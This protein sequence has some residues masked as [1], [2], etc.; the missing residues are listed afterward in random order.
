MVNDMTEFMDSA[1]GRKREWCLKDKQESNC[2]KLYFLDEAWSELIA[3]DK[4]VTFST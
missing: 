2:G 1:Y 3:N 4:P